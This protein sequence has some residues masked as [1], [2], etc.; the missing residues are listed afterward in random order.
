MQICPTEA[1][2]SE[3]DNATLRISFDRSICPGCGL[4]ERQC[5]E[6]DR[7][8]ITV[9]RSAFLGVDAPGRAA[10]VEQRQPLC[11]ICGAPIASAGMLSRVEEML[12]SG[13]AGNS[14]VIRVI[15]TRCVKC[16]GL[17]A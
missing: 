4:C 11:A 8:A 2:R 15:G 5:P 16:R 9:R 7:G 12:R 17:G 6:R 3:K 13:G 14:E 1:L 10:L